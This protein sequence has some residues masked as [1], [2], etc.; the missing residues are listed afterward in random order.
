VIQVVLRSSDVCTDSLRAE[1]A[2]TETTM[3]QKSIERPPLFHVMQAATDSSR[4]FETNA[5][6]DKLGTLAR[7]HFGSMAYMLLWKLDIYASLTPQDDW[8]STYILGGVSGYNEKTFID[9]RLVNIEP[10]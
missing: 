4:T 3:T 9:R 6:T 2:K 7:I 10:W 1:S 5:L 8:Y